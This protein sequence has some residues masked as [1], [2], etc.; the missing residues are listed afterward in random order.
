MR[1]QAERGP[2]GS[3]EG[4]TWG[5]MEFEKHAGPH[6]PTRLLKVLSLLHCLQLAMEINCHPLP[7]THYV[8][9]CFMANG[10]C[11]MAKREVRPRRGL[12]WRRTRGG[13]GRRPGAQAWG[14]PL[15]AMR[16][17]P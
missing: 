14:A 15:L 4:T 8:P 12:Q 17:E 10:L 7:T 2:I 9:L 11:V 16:H 6:D 3:Q 5:A 1:P 13:G